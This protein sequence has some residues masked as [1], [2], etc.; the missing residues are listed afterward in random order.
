[1]PPRHRYVL[2]LLAALDTGAL[3]DAAA[4]LA[5]MDAAY[6]YGAS[7]N[8]ELRMRWCQL[9]IKQN[10]EPGFASVR[11]FLESQGKIRYTVPI[12]RMLLNGSECVCHVVLCLLSRCATGVSSVMRACLFLFSAAKALAA[13]TFEATKPAL[14]LS[15]IGILERLMSGRKK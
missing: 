1:V 3:V 8:A 13:A 11:A 14:H 7:I 5:A 10:W 9:V 6:K 2:D 4:S 12:Y 15:V